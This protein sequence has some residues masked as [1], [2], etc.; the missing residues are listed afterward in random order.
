MEIDAP[1]SKSPLDSR[2]EVLDA[3]GNSIER[4]RLQAVRDTWLTFRGKNSMT[5]NDFRLFKWRE[6][7]LNQLLYVNGEVVKLWHSPRGPDSG[8]IVYPGTGNRWGYFDTTPLAHPL[9][10]NAY[11]VEAIATGD[12]PRPNGLPVFTIHFENDDQS[13]RRW[14]NDSQ[15]TFTAPQD[16][17][18]LVRV[19][20]IRGFQGKEFKYTLTLRPRRPT[21]R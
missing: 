9:G 13:H 6:M 19:S 12:E 2:V 7:S 5:A 17:E 10:Q 21:S 20:D 3:E 11:I 18:Y 16:G 1:R 15:L 14:G 4:I 8:Y